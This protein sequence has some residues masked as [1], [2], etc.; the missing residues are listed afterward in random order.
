MT[1][2]RGPAPAGISVRVPEPVPVD[3]TGVTTPPASRRLRRAESGC[4]EDVTR[5]ELPEAVWASCSSPGVEARPTRAS[6]VTASP[7]W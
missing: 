1:R 4:A 5:Q 2:V 7:S 3:A 6:A